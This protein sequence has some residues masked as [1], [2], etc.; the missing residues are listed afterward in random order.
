MGES[1]SRSPA[2]KALSARLKAE[3]VPCTYCGTA[4]A[5]SIDHVVELWMGGDNHDPENWAPACMRCNV[6]KSNKLRKAHAERR[7]RHPAR[8]YRRPKK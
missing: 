4:R 1:R 2:Y 8:T 5:N 6:D 7:S 3:Y